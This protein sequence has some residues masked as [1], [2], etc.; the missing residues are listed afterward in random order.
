MKGEIIILKRKLSEKEIE[1][2]MEKALKKIPFE[3]K[4][5]KFLLSIVKSFK[6]IKSIFN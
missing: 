3:I 4:K 1:A 5:I 2:Q 6:K